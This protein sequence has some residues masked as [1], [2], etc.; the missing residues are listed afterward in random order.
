MPKVEAVR[1]RKRSQR[2]LDGLVWC[3]ILSVALWMLPGCDGAQEFA[4]AD[5]LTTTQ[6]A[7]EAAVD[8]EGVVDGD[9]VEG[10]SMVDPPE[11]I[12]EELR[13]TDGPRP[14][15]DGSDARVRALEMPTDSARQ[16]PELPEVARALD[17]FDSRW[18]R[19]GTAEAHASEQARQERR[20]EAKL[21][22]LQ[23]QGLLPMTE[24]VTP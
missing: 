15:P 8:P 3:S 5:E 1:A 2:W 17:D 23:E 14:F 16:R 9:L 12:I 6:Q 7:V 4:P 18:S 11:P 10:G 22:W 24:E 21:A 19:S 20:M 13:D